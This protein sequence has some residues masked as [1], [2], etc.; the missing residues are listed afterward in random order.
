MTDGQGRCRCKLMSN[1]VTLRAS[2]RGSMGLKIQGTLDRCSASMSMSLSCHDQLFTKKGLACFSLSA[3]SNRRGSVMASRFL[4]SVLRYFRRSLEERCRLRVKIISE[5]TKTTEF[6]RKLRSGNIFDVASNLSE[7]LLEPGLQRLEEDRHGLHLL[8]R[9][10]H[11]ILG[12]RL[13][14]QGGTNH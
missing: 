8:E 14:R 9:D 4:I 11:F 12:H 10:L 3:F 1:S 7:L 2:A 5:V 6:I 13:S